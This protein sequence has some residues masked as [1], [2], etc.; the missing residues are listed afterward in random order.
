MVPLAVC[1]PPGR[2]PICSLHILLPDIRGLKQ[3]LNVPDPFRHFWHLLPASSWE[4]DTS[5]SNGI[6]V[7]SGANSMGRPAFLALLALDRKL[8]TSRRSDNCSDSFSF[9]VTAKTLSRHGIG[10]LTG[11]VAIC[12]PRGFK[13]GLKWNPLG[14]KISARVTL[15]PGVWGKGRKSLCGAR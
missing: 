10:R 4:Q 1:A 9:H 2:C 7:G 3:P 6:C 11:R 5:R 14:V 15:L 8:I 13:S 12:L